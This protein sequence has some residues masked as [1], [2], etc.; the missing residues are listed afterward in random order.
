MAAVRSTCASNS[1]TARPASCASAASISSRCSVAMSRLA[2]WAVGPRAGP[3][4]V[5][6]GGAGQPRADVEQDGVAARLDQL[7][8]ERDVRG[9]PVVVPAVRVVRAVD[10]LAGHPVVGGEHLGFPADA[11]ALDRQP[12]RRPFV[13]LPRHGQ[14][15]QGVR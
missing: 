11:A 6:L 12:Q 10:R 9:R 14:V 5:Q 4:A 15:R 8:V 2:G 7:V 1:R 3:G 13:D